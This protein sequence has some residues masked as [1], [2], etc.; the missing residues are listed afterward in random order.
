MWRWVWCRIVIASPECLLS[1]QLAH[2]FFWGQ[3][4]HCHLHVV[5]STQRKVLL[6]R[7]IFPRPVQTCRRGLLLTAESGE[8][9]SPTTGEES[10]R[11][12]TKVPV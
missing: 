7:S 3:L 5:S 10:E 9:S 8:D 2:R 4:V 6:R 11:A 1:E 12:Q